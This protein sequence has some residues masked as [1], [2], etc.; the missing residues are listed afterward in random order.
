MMFLNIHFGKPSSLNI[1]FAFNVPVLKLFHQENQNPFVL[2]HTAVLLIF[3][4][5][6]VL[7]L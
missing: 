6:G 1:I 5:C 2:L 7:Y 3:D 4:S